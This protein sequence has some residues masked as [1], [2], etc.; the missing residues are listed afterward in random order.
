MR[1]WPL[2]VIEP[3]ALHSA[4]GWKD[5]AAIIVATLVLAALTKRYLEDPVRTVAWWRRLVP[6]YA[7]GAAGMAVVLAVAATWSGVENHRQDRYQRQLVAQVASA[8]GCFGAAAL[9]PGSTCG[10]S[11][12]GEYV[13]KSST[14]QRGAMP[15][16]CRHRCRWC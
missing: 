1:H 6:T 11:R 14:W 7:M 5:D 16:M 9:D 2:L 12:Q 3:A 15:E 4:R 10:R 13:P 8:E